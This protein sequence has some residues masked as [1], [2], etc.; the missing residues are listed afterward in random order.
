[1]LADPV[2]AR[3]HARLPA[4]GELASQARQ[5]LAPLT[6]LHM[7]T[8]VA[9]PAEHFTNQQIQQMAAV[10]SEHLAKVPPITV[11]LSKILYHPKAIMLA[12][13]PVG[14]LA[15]IRAA[16]LAATKSVASVETD[17]ESRWTPHV[18]VCYSTAEQPA[19]PVITA[20]GKELPARQLDIDAMSL[21]IQDGPER[22][23]NWTT[24]GAIRLHA[25][26]LA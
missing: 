12:V 7:T 1:V 10:A 13:T 11:S 23:W 3:A 17:E 2:L 21:V 6:G 24:V 19:H 14:D 25:A 5:R 9:G 15:P 22:A 20:L 8:P 4:S 26:A 18:T 16:A